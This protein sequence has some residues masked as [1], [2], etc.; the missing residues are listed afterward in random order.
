MT[1]LDEL[2]G[3]L[4][5]QYLEPSAATLPQE[6]IVESIRLSLERIN[7]W[8]SERFEIQGLDGS[9]Q[10]TLPDDFV[11]CLLTG[12]GANLTRFMLQAH[13][14]SYTNMGGEPELMRDLSAYLEERFVWMLEGLRLD[15]LQKS[16]DIPFA[17]WKWEENLTWRT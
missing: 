10:D 11:A 6:T 9:T 5:K 12:A 14:S 3:R 2:C 7:V 1:R 13:L 17:P 4:S 8:F 16:V 15:S